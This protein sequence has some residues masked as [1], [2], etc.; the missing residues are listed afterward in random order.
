MSAAASVPMPRSRASSIATST[1]TDCPAIVERILK[2]YVAHRESP[3]EP[4][5]AF[6]R[7][8]DTERLKRLCDTE[9]VE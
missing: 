7:R 8:Y 3:E 6:T 9:A 5:V 4:F 2:A 1:A